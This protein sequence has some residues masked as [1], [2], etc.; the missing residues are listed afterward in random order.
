MYTDAHSNDDGI[1]FFR[2]DKIQASTGTS[3]YPIKPD[4]IMEIV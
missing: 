3:S 2:Y 4:L 1:A